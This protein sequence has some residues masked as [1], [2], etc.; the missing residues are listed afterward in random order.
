MSQYSNHLFYTKS[1]LSMCALNTVGQ[2]LISFSCPCNTVSFPDV[3]VSF[4][5]SNNIL[6]AMIEDTFYKV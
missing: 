5:I 6:A 1:S 3:Q 4:P 2:K